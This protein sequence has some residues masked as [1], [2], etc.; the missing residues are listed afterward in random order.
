[1]ARKSCDCIIGDAHQGEP[2][3]EIVNQSDFLRR[4]GYSPTQGWIMSSNKEAA[5]QSGKRKTTKG[6]EPGNRKQ[7]DRQLAGRA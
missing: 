2:V 4:C 1:M 6:P 5:K 3:R 7:V